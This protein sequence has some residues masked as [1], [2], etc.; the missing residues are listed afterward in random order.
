MTPNERRDAKAIVYA[1]ALLV[2]APVPLPSEPLPPVPLPPE[3]L[4]PP[5]GTLFISANEVG[6]KVL[7]VNV[8]VTVVESPFDIY[9]LSRWGLLNRRKVILH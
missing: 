7:N 1:K 3:P 5:T 6:T 8:K 4:P 9:I 2:S